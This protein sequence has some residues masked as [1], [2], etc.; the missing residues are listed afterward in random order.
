MTQLIE[1]T[2]DL[3]K[4]G[5][6]VPGW[7][8]PTMETNGVPFRCMAMLGALVNAGHPVVWFDQSVDGYEPELVVEPMRDVAVVFIWW[9]DLYPTSQSEN[10]LRLAWKLKA[11]FPEKLL[12]C[13]GAFF[14]TCPA[15]ALFVEGPVDF[16][17]RSPGEQAVPALLAAL[18]GEGS[19]EDVSG[20]VW[21]NGT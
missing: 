5:V 13:G 2:Q 17:V 7:T 16:F 1:G 3:Q 9:A 10:A 4:I 11:A 19:L 8:G 20:L 6:V 12:V 14:R 18:R 21:K 15:E